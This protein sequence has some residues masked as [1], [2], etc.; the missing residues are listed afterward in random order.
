MWRL[1]E[2]D[3]CLSPSA[4]NRKCVVKVYKFSATSKMMDFAIFDS[5]IEIVNFYNKQQRP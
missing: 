4:Y 5:M 2:D 3:A 1:L